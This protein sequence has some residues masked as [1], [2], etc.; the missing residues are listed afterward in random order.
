MTNYNQS[1]VKMWRRC[2]KQFAFRYDYADEGMELV[3][4]ITKA[5]LSR[6]T[7]L[8]ALIEAYFREE[9]GEDADWREVHQQYVDKFNTYFDEEKEELGD[10]PTECL[11]I[12]KAYLRFYAKDAERYQTATLSDGSPA[13]ELVLERTLP[14]GENFK[15]RVDRVVEDLE[16]GGH[17][18]WDHKWVR[19]IPDTD[20]RMMS[21]QAPMYVWGLQPIFKDI[22]GFLYNYGRT[23][24]P[25]VPQKLVRGGISQRKN[26]DTDLHTYVQALKE[27]YGDDWKK[28][29]KLLYRDTLLRLKERDVLWFRRERVPVEADRIERCLDEFLLSTV[30]ISSR[31]DGEDAP[32][33][34][35]YNCKFGCEYHGLCVGEF[36]GLNIEPLIKAKFQQVGERYESTEADLLSG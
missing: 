31:V 26:M 3:P 36:T 1:K 28:A 5:P 7:W 24:P 22:R 30:Q 9:A 20:E 6:G 2:Q 32:R 21:P 4:K 17:W 10:L 18:I 12:F 27:E 14:N 15:G 34:Y 23:K 11:R 33:S 35:F 16:Y 19:T 25:T 8:H 29:A 13:I